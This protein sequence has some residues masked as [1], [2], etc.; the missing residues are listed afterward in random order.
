MAQFA[1]GDKV[2]IN[3]PPHIFE[4]VIIMP[5]AMAEIAAVHDDGTYTLLYYDREMMPHR[6]PGIQEHEIS[7]A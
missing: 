5:G 2:K 6:M 7:K 3:K 4:G 1:V